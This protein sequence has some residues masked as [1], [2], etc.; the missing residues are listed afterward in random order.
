MR[1]SDWSSD[2]C[3]SDLGNNLAANVQHQAQKFVRNNPRHL[4]ERRD[5]HGCAF[6]VR[7]QG[8]DRDAGFQIENFAGDAV[9]TLGQIEHAYLRLFYRHCDFALCCHDFVPPPYYSDGMT[10]GVAD[11]FEIAASTAAREA[12]W[13]FHRPCPRSTP[14][15]E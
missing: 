7:P 6:L 4:H 15:K 9:F 10:K 12:D 5:R 2:V 1:I 8:A 13:R 11:I 3:S 14:D